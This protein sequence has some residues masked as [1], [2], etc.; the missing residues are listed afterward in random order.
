MDAAL[1]LQFL[2][3][4]RRRGVRVRHQQLRHQQATGR[5]HETR[6]Q[7][8]FDSRAESDVTRKHGASDRRDA[9]T[10]DGEQLRFGQAPQVGLHDQRR[11][12]LANK[13]VRRRVHG[14][15]RPGA[16]H[17][18]QEAADDAHEVF[19]DAQVVHDRHQRREEDDDRQHVDRKTETDD[20]GVRQ[21]SKQEVDARLRIANHREHAAADPVDDGAAGIDVKHQSSD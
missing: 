10:H 11:L 12:G 15:D 3:L 16:N 4:G 13:N 1:D 18:M 14:F 6:R 9:G 21:R 7:Q 20:L 8:V 19:H 2:V 17:S 5:R